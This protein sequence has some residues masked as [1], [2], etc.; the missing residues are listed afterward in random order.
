MLLY[1]LKVLKQTGQEN[2][3]GPIRI[4]DG[5]GIQY[6]PLFSRPIGVDGNPSGGAV[7]LSSSSSSSSSP[8]A[9]SFLPSSSSTP[10]S[11]CRL[12]RNESPE[13]RPAL[14]VGKPMRRATVTSPT[15]EPAPDSTSIGSPTALTFRSA[16]KSPPTPCC[17]WWPRLLTLA[18]PASS[19]SS[20]ESASPRLLRR[21]SS[22]ET[23][24]S[25]RSGSAYRSGGEGGA[26]GA[27]GTAG[28]VG[29]NCRE[30]AAAGKGVRA[31]AGCAAGW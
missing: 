25:D 4:C 18:G 21:S 7:A 20:S 28:G 24:A 16:A 6:C 3:V 2:C 19:S 22:R 8:P 26:Y 12:G 9:P 5:V 17:W 13:T 23:G 29:K 14:V 15:A 30:Y 1:R 11:C 10:L 27:V 31:G